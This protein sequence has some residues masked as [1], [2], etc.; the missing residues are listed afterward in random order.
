MPR[1]WQEQERWVS[2]CQSPTCES[3]GKLPR[4]KE[5]LS[6]EDREGKGQGEAWPRHW[7]NHESAVARQLKAG[8]ETSV[9]PMMLAPGRPGP[10]RP[11][12]LA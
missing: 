12:D 11:G 9:E 2:M 3:Q 5:L 8:M 6:E 1:T 4:Q 10:C 7:R